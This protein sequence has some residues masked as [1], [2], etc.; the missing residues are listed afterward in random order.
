MGGSVDGL[1][2][3]DV[4]EDEELLAGVSV[5]T[6]LKVLGDNWSVD[7]AVVFE[8]EIIEVETSDTFTG[9]PITLVGFKTS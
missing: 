2:T 3:D 6:S 1:T 8:V 5:E 4:F 9:V 7:S